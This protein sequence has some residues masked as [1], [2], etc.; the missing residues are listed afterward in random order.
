MKFIT[1]KVTKFL[2]ALALIFCLGAIAPMIQTF[3]LEGSAVA[4]P[5]PRMEAAAKGAL[6]PRKLS[7][8][9][10][11]KVLPQLT[12]WSVLNGKLHKSFKF[13]NFIQ[14]F[15]F[16]SKV[17]IVAEKL[18]HHPEIYNVYNVATLDLTTHDAGGISQLDIELALQINAL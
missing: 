12:G 18:E 9:E 15:G 6:I 16:L 5:L 3:E 10:I 8:A 7:D 4:N 2:P 13:T 11:K 14:A 17:A 1:I